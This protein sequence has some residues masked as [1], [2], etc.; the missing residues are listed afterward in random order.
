MKKFLS[1]IVLTLLMFTSV[2]VFAQSTSSQEST[3]SKIDLIKSDLITI[4]L[5]A[6]LGAALALF[7]DAVKHFNTSS[8]SWSIFLHTK[9]EPFAIVTGISALMVIAQVISGSN[10]SML[11]KN[12]LGVEFTVLSS[13]TLFGFAATIYDNFTKKKSVS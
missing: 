5:P 12:L 3:I 9:I 10:F 8:W 6:M 11:V 13:A 7:S 4:F 2:L 1:M